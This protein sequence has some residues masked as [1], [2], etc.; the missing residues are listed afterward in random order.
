M[1]VWTGK[2]FK[3]DPGPS[4]CHNDPASPGYAER[5]RQKVTELPGGTLR[6]DIGCEGS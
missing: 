6:V 3:A 2:R 1:R 5:H 4:V